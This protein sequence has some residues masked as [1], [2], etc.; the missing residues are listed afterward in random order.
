MLTVLLLLSCL[1]CLLAYRWYGKFLSDRCQLDDHRMTPANAKEDGIDFVPA[2]A[3]VLF[4]HHFSSIAGAGPIVGPILAATYFGWGPTWAWILIGAILVGG[5]HDFGSTLMSVR[6]GGRSI[7]DTMRSLVGEGAGKLFMLFVVLALIYVIIVFLDLTANTFAKQPAVASASGWFIVVAVIFGFL[8]RSGK[9]SLGKLSI[10]FFPLTFAGLA[11]GHFFPMVELG[12]DFWI[13]AT[14]GYCFV[15]AVLPVGLLLQPRDFLSAGFLYAILVV[16]VLG[17]LIS[18]ETLRMPAF[19][20]WESE[21]LGMLVPFL[22]IT[23]ACGACSGFHSIVSSGTTS[24]QIKRESDVRRISYGGMLVEGVLAVF[25]M[26]CV[27]V[28]TISERETGGNPVGLFAAGA[29]KFFGAVGIPTN[30]GAEFAMLAISTFLLTTLDTCTRLTRFLIEE[31]FAWRN[32]T[33]RYLGT[34]LALVLPAILVFQQFPA[35]NGS[36]QPAWKAIWPLFGATNQL[37]AALA[38]LTFVVFL[39]ASKV[40]YGFALLPAV[41]MMVMPMIALALMAWE[42]GLGSLIGG[43]SGAMFLLGFF[44]MGSSWRSLAKDSGTEALVNSG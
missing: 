14:L 9:S 22:F 33:S 15:A 19:T 1:L 18:G 37:L 13:Y 8:M 27:A 3:S 43:T 30:L 12:K 44:L 28:L 38:L 23:V 32:E 17:M 26:G 20:G 21:K 6:N 16:G 7:A 36:L 2:R 24:K 40:G 10:L 4:G 34:L 29:A 39:K 5:V 35:A 41:V 42:H 25:A 31:L 11:V